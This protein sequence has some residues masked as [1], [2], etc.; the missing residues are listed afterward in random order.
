MSDSVETATCGPYELIAQHPESLFELPDG[1]LELDAERP[2]LVRLGRGASRNTLRGALDIPRNGSEGLLQFGNF[3]GE[4]D[5]GGRRL[6]VRS[7]RLTSEAVDG[8]LDEVAEELASLPFGADTPTATSYTRD[9]SDAPN[10]LYHSYAFL[11]DCIN[12]RGPHDL[13][14]AVE[15]ILARPHESLQSGAPRLSPLGAASRVDA[16]TL[17]SLQ[18]DPELLSPV[19]DGS[20]LANHPLAQRLGGRMPEFIRTRPLTHST[21]NPENR[22]VVSALDAMTDI[23]RRFEQFARN[24]GRVSASINAKEA[25]DIAERLQRWRRHRVL[26]DVPNAGT[27]AHQSSVLRGRAGYRELLRIYVDLLARSRL[28]S[29]HD[30][31]ALLELRDAALIYEYWCYFRMCAAVRDFIGEAPKLSR[32]ET[33]PL[34]T[35]VP[36]GYRATW[37]GVVLAYNLTFASRQGQSFEVGRDSYSVRLRPDITLHAFGHLHLFDAKLKRQLQAALSAEDA[38]DG[39]GSDTFKREDLYKMHAY[40]DAL[41]AES[42]WVL[43]PGSPSNP[44]RF[45]APQPHTADPDSSTFKGVGAIG[46]R[47]NA[48]HDGG[49]RDVVCELLSLQG[50]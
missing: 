22:F 49:L 10:V 17:T 4:S 12:A 20:P 37:E 50:S 9:R 2:Y 47:P 44:Q 30:E 39:E 8:M 36:Y 6:F 14:G 34:H 27:A 25:R 15:R 35:L 11:R 1:S 28:A 48:S 45:P 26:E 13:T 43:Y 41:N 5:L 19:P 23:A 7:T 18:R 46:L 31:Q 42:V 29:P 16:T 33:S 3:I 38:D 32:F 21:D 24:R 40:R